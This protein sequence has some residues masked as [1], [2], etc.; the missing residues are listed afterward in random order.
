MALSL[1]QKHNFMLVLLFSTT[2]NPEDDVNP[3]D[4]VGVFRKSEIGSLDWGPESK[5]NIRKN[6]KRRAATNYRRMLSIFGIKL[7][8][9]DIKAG[10]ENDTEKIDEIV[11]KWVKKAQ[12]L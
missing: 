12:F 6:A 11:A 1:M 8:A 10:L 4:S 2:D 5:P 9:A 3:F 7:L